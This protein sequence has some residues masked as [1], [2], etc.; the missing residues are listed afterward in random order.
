M[1]YEIGRTFGVWH[2]AHPDDVPATVRPLI[3][4]ED[5]GYIRVVHATDGTATYYRH[6]GET[7]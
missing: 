4:E 7:Q 5:V 2:Q 1:T 3:E 6:R